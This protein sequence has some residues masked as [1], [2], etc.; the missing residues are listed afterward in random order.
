MLFNATIS[1]STLKIRNS[2]A[3]K[4]YLSGLSGDVVVDIGKRKA[5]RTTQQN[6]FYWE[7]LSIIEKETGEDAN[8]IHEIAKRKFLPPQFVT[9]KGQEYKLPAST[10][11]LSK[12]DFGFYLD[13][14][15]SWTGIEI[16]KL[17]Y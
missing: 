13:K 12:Q 8:T 11:K 10:T 5:N 16:P 3:W 2:E 4:K 1:N 6:R 7:Y 15:C 14:I 9:I 17:E